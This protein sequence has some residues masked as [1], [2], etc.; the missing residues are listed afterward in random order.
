MADEC[1]TRP[2]MIVR[3]HRRTDAD[4][5]AEILAAGWKYAYGG[6]L[7]DGV[8]ATH[9]DPGYRQAEI[10]QWLDGEFDPMNEAIFVAEDGGAVSGFIHIELGD[11]DE[12][13][14]TGVVNLIYVDPEMLGRG[15]GRALMGAGARWLMERRPGPLALS[16]FE[17]NSSRSFYNRLGGIEAKRIHRELWGSSIET[18]LYLWPQPDIL[19]ADL[20]QHM[21]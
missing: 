17:Q 20:V 7:P 3:A 4:R 2:A 12:L 5:I 14:A 1:G 13:G 18:V 9:T 16:A 21:D 6:F 11:R 10:A 15:L 8:L 19:F